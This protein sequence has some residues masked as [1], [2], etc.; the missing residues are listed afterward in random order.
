[1]NASNIISF[2]GVRLWLSDEKHWI[3]L[4]SI[5]VQPGFQY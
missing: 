1:M 3:A 5:A 2:G 4:D